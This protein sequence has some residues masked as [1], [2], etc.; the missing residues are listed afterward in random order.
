MVDLFRAPPETIVQGKAW[1]R[2]YRLDDPTA[3]PPEVNLTGYTG[4][5]LVA[6]EP[7]E[8]AIISGVLEFST[9]RFIVSMTA[10]QTA[11]L[12]ALPIIGG[13]PS[14][15]LQITLTG[16]VEGVGAVIQGQV[17]VAGVSA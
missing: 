4:T 9:P 5:W 2:S 8:D 3:E 15:M 6:P 1:S 10:A 12:T 16:P 7:F 11:L 14:G 17:I 13:R